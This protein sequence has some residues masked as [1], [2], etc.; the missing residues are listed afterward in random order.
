MTSE[1]DEIQNEQ[2]YEDQLLGHHIQAL[3]KDELGVCV[4][5]SGDVKPNDDY[6][7]LVIFKKIEV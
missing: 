6:V 1:E 3:T 2:V 5:C 7:N 4:E